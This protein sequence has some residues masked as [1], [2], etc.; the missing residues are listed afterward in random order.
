MS[1]DLQSLPWNISPLPSHPYDAEEC[2]E[3]PFSPCLS[4]F[5]LEQ[6][7]V[8]EFQTFTRKFDTT[9][10]RPI[11]FQV[12]LLR[13]G[14]SYRIINDTIRKNAKFCIGWYD[15]YRKSGCLA[16]FMIV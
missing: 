14:K 2:L 6:A 15:A 4:G 3:I 13:I 9:F 12:T 10:F 7:I 8:L 16:A 1:P 11:Y 5:G